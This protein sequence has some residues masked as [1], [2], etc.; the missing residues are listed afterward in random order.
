MDGMRLGCL[1]V[2]AV[3]LARLLLGATGGAAS[4]PPPPVGPFLMMYNGSDSSGPYEIGEAESVD[5]RSWT[6][7]PSNP[8]IVP[9]VGTLYDEDVKD[10]RLLH[11]GS[12]FVCYFSGYDG[13]HL[14]VFRATRTNWTDA[15]SIDST[16]VLDVGTSGAFD[17]LHVSYVSVLYEPDDTGKQWKLWY[18]AIKASDGIVRVGYAYSSDGIN[19]TKV[20]MVLDVGAPGQWDALTVGPAAIFKS[21]GTYYLF[22]HGWGATAK[23]A[24]LATFTDPEGTYS[25]DAGN[26]LFSNTGISKTLTVTTSSG[27]SVVTLNNTTGLHVAEQVVLS[28][29]NSVAENHVV[30]SIDSGTQLTL[31]DPVTATFATGNS[32]VLRSFPYFGIGIRSVLRVDGEWLMYGSPFQ[33]I[34]DL[35]VSGSKLREGNIL[36]T[37]PALNG[38]W[39]FE[40][41][42]EIFALY[43]RNTTAWDS[44]SAENLSV[45]VAP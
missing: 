16:P 13:T 37:S 6:K 30:A 38:P 41:P 44:I 25:R 28:D 33:P 5:G 21:G 17:D 36:L 7:S 8:T 4:F 27:S 15:W 29:N 40:Y 32:A 24:G 2:V 34:E 14:R 45:I 43:P 18:S 22:Y 42:S 3:I 39:A 35:T 10:P 23:R 31:E 9:A 19:F 26:P 11:D 1:P 12:Q 20:G